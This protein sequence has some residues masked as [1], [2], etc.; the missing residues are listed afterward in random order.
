MSGSPTSNGQWL[1][2]WLSFAHVCSWKESNV[3]EPRYRYSQMLKYIWY[4]TLHQ[5]KN[6]PICAAKHYWYYFLICIGYFLQIV[7]ISDKNK[8]CDIKLNVGDIVGISRAQPLWQ[9]DNI[10]SEIIMLVTGDWQM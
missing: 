7:L 9:S 1:M 5:T 6:V 4:G 3:E 10:K 2:I 8:E